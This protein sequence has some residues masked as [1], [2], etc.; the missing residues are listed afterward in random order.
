MR[1]GLFLCAFLVLA[2]LATPANA[3]VEGK[4][5]GGDTAWMLVSTGL[6]LLMVP[7][8]ALFYGG[9][10]RRKNVLGTMMHSMVAL[11]LVGVQWVLLGYCLAFGTTQG[12]W[13][14]WDASYIGLFVLG[15]G[16]VRKP[17]SGTGTPATE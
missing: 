4:I 1:T 9:L 14:G 8:L 11:A 3:A 7:G 10:V 6:V 17:E 2:V 12:G 15:I 13:I 16:L 5:D